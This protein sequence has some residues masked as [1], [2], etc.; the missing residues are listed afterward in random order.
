M[1]QSA[2]LTNVNAKRINQHTNTSRATEA[3]EEPEFSYNDVLYDE[4]S[5]NVK[6]HKY[7]TSNNI[8]NGSSA[9][10]TI[11]LNTSSRI[12]TN[13]SSNPPTKDDILNWVKKLIDE[14]IVVK[15]DA[16]GD[17]NVDLNDLKVMVDRMFDD[18][19]EIKM[20]NIDIDNDGK[21][22]LDDL[23][24]VIDIIVNQ[25]KEN[26]E[27]NPPIKEILKGDVNGDGKI[28]QE[29][30]KLISK[31]YVGDNVEID[32]NNADIDDNG[33]ITL[34]DVSQVRQW[35]N[36]FDPQILKGD[37]NGD[38]IV[39]YKDVDALQRASINLGGKIDMEA[40]DFDGDGEITSVDIAKTTK[41][42][43]EYEAKFQKIIGDSNGDGVI[44]EKDYT[45][46]KNYINNVNSSDDF[47]KKNS[48]I[49]G[50]GQVDDEDLKRLRDM[51]DG[52]NVNYDKKGLVGDVNGDGEVTMSDIQAI[53]NYKN[54]RATGN[55]II[56]N[57]ADLNK[58]GKIDTKD[59]ELALKIIQIGDLN[60]DKKITSEDM[61]SIQAIIDGR[62]VRARGIGDAN[63]DGKVDIKDYP[64]IRD[65]LM[66][67][68][69]SVENEAS[70]DMNGDGKVDV[71]DLAIWVK[72]TGV[73]VEAKAGDV[74]ADGAIDQKDVDDLSR[75]L[76]KQTSNYVGVNADVNNDG[77]VDWDDVEG[78][79]NMIDSPY[80]FPDHISKAGIEMIK[81]FEGFRENAYILPGEDAYTIGYGH[82][83][84]DVKPG[85]TITR[86]QAEA[87][88]RQ[89]LLEAEGYVKQYCS[90]FK[91]NQNQ[92]D[93]LVSFTFNCG[94]KNL[95][96]LIRDNR[97]LEELPEHMP[98]YCH[99][100]AG[101]KLKG[102]V[103][104]R[105]AEV[106]LFNT[107][108]N[109]VQ[110]V[111]S[112]IPDPGTS[113]ISSSL[114]NLINQWNGKTWKDHTY[115]SNVSQCKEFSSYIFNELYGTGY[116]GSGSVS[117]NYY[118]WRLSGTP[119]NVYQVA[120]VKPTFNKNTARNAFQEMFSNAQPGDFIQI[121]RGSM[122]PHSAI[123]VG[124]TDDGVQW[125][126]ANADGKNSIKLQTYKYDDLV[127]TTNSG[128]QW[129]V[130]MSLYR[131]K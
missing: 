92:F 17:G 36:K 64:V 3:Y 71:E 65:Y 104:R 21:I 73:V 60:R 69:S 1:Y 22:S 59:S 85:M 101:R 43:N 4:M 46:V 95:K 52:L 51:A 105:E 57:N 87:Y 97:P 53:N 48:D 118:N 72:N 8:R 27:P 89:D 91:L 15:G 74:N 5:R 50:D 113:Q 12:A 127:K 38:G 120:E 40:A 86:E 66:G 2:L 75:F 100:A 129:N 79:K 58:D 6:R 103:N 55:E 20:E 76:N 109:S 18:T 63:G 49:N 37:A 80:H 29:D 102:L 9:N 39:N 56:F 24:K 123:F 96:Y 128:H 90:H 124:W 70:A 23:E 77:N 31:Y 28:T 16:N 114:Q 32:M 25:G 44:N 30:A 10:A 84:A 93:A 83:G 61:E 88:L 110:N 45:N 94:V 11:T 35:A 7:N 126:D 125:L 13:K 131:A 106:A 62:Q 14:K 107:P 122:S 112:S 54:R 47:V 108:V 119:S 34:A 117:S 67:F 130:A 41:L 98:S 99:D 33:K 115:L 19:V 111:Q 68:R 81:N 26:N 82:K 116:I 42:A 121:K 78:I